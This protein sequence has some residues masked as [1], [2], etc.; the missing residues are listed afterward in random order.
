MLEGSLRVAGNRVGGGGSGE[1]D[2]ETSADINILGRWKEPSTSVSDYNDT[3][4]GS[5]M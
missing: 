1:E 5:G 3:S 2:G 4:F